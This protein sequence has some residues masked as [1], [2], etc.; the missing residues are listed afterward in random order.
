MTHK[1]I[2]STQ[3]SM[4]LKLTPSS[5]NLQKARKRQKKDALAAAANPSAPTPPCISVVRALPHF[6]GT[7]LSATAK[8]PQPSPQSTPASRESS[9]V[10]HPQHSA[11]PS[12][13]DQLPES[14]ARGTW[15][16]EQLVLMGAA[17]PSL[18]SGGKTMQVRA[19][20]H[21]AL[22]CLEADLLHSHPQHVQTCSSSVQRSCWQTS[23]MPC[24]ISALVC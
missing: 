4:V 14:H 21:L 8:S 16:T 3:G 15:P 5:Y 13:Q 22:S 2:L 6:G 11:G 1:T 20:Y 23:Q 24:L 17:G 10:D 18:Q 7:S 12:S 9:G 19:P